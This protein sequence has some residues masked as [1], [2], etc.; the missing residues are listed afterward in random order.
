MY[1]NLPVYLVTTILTPLN[2]KYKKFQVKKVCQVDFS[3]LQQL[4]SRVFVK[5]IKL[6]M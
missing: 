1:Q 3:V 6:Y 2:R 4:Y 5:R